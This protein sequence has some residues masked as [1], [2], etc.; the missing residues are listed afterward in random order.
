MEMERLKINLAD[1]GCSSRETERILQ[2][3]ESGNVADALQIMK[4]SRCKLMEEMHERGR[5]VDC[6]DDLIRRTMK[7]MK[8][9]GGR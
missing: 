1:A 7:E 8:Q 5:K 4:K 3:Y 9:P 2:M 6:L